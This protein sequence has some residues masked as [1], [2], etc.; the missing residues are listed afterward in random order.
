MELTTGKLIVA[1]NPL[2]ESWNGITITPN[3]G[4]T[5]RECLERCTIF[6]PP[7]K[8]PVIDMVIACSCGKTVEYK[9]LDD[10]PD[11]DVPCNCNPNYYFVKIGKP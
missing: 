10:I 4:E 11:H 2:C 7:N 8:R 3:E 9:T 6:D 5:V 1:S